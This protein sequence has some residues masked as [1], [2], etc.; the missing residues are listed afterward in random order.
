MRK[1]IFLLTAV[2][3][4]FALAAGLQV[5]WPEVGGIKPTGSFGPGHWI[6]YIFVFALS[7]VG[8]AVIAAF[9]WAGIEYMTAG[10]NSS[11]VSSAKS[12][13][14]SAVQGLIILLGSYI[15][16]NTINPDLINIREPKVEF[17]IESH[18][19]GYYDPERKKPTGGTCQYDG[20]CQSNKC[21][22]TAG[23][24]EAASQAQ[25]PFPPKSREN[26]QT[27]TE[28]KECKSDVCGGAASARVCIPF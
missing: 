10:D 20:D 9:V 4:L 19:R 24:C 1:I 23:Y 22:T 15:V 11:K 28:N 6:Q 13:M 27:C 7:I 16:L 17:Y 14:W 21:N 5:D 12:R 2:S 26:G 8:L 25:G 18:W 3:P